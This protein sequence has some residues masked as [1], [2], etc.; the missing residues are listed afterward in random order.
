LGLRR[1]LISGEVAL[2]FVLLVS[3]AL[4]AQSLAKA[5]Q[6]DP[7]F[8]P[9]GVM[10]AGL[11]L[12]A[13][14]YAGNRE[15]A[16]FY[17]SLR[18][19]LDERLGTHSTAVIDE[20]PLTGDGG[21]TLVGV[22]PAEARAEAVA[23]VASPSYFEVMGIPVVAGREFDVGDDA[24]APPRALV[25]AQLAIRLF[26]T[27][28]AVGR[29]IYLAGPRRTLEIVGV[30]GDVMLRSVDDAPL[31]TVYLSAAQ[32]P[33]RTSRI[34]VRAS[35]A[36]ADVVAIVRDE[37]NRLDREL[38]AYGAVAMTEIVARSPGMPARR[39]LTGTL[40]AF[41]FLAM[42]LSAVGLFGVVA[43]DVATR[44]AELA[45]RLAL[46]AH[47]RRLLASA[48]YQGWIMIGSGVAAGVVLSWWSGRLLT[49]LA[50]A[51]ESFDVATSAAAAALVIGV[52]LFAIF[53]AAR[54]AART[55]PLSA[56]RG[57]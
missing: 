54:R 44:R 27:A 4:L 55:D 22:T 8:R 46:G 35:R 5:L 36:P 51:T 32:E 57:D 16:A 7:G 43:H 33:S 45:V 34:V 20:L 15:E 11:S 56:L 39:V 42:A 47:P 53:P 50:P 25:G 30:V 24:S 17:A 21:R 52:G 14:R 3:M 23:R 48:L 41:A 18:Q 29:T 28:A 31:D 19:A 38:P 1:L 37:V 49:A 13:A 10:T 26:G 6:R 2:A 40:T 12:P 9:D